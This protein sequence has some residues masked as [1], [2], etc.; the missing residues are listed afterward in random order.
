MESLAGRTDFGLES[1]FCSIL[2]GL[3]TYELELGNID[4]SVVNTFY[5]F[6]VSME[7]SLS[8][9]LTLE[10]IMVHN[11]KMTLDSFEL[12]EINVSLI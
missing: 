10:S 5:D 1:N 7:L 2:Y 9:Y 3:D 8:V 11:R 4:I 6:H 12:H